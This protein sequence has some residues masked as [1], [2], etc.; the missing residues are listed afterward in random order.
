MVFHGKQGEFFP[1]RLV[2][3]RAEDK[4]EVFQGPFPIVAQCGA[5]NGKQARESPARGANI[6]SEKKLLHSPQ[7]EPLDIESGGNT[8]GHVVRG[9]FGPRAVACIFYRRRSRTVD[10]GYR[11]IGDR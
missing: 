5:K 1:L 4:L 2:E 7:C 3:V 10:G 9:Q 6:P 8:V 11:C